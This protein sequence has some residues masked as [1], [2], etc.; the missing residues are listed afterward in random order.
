MLSKADYFIIPPKIVLQSVTFS[1]LFENVRISTEI[2]FLCWFERIFLTS[3]I[4]FDLQYQL[5]VKNSSK[6]SHKHTHKKNTKLQNYKEIN[7]SE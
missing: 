7:K 2:Y 4:L 1:L 5:Q 3:T 6:P